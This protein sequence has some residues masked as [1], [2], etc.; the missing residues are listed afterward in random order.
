MALRDA[1]EMH[2]RLFDPAIAAGVLMA[3]YRWMDF[4]GDG[5]TLYQVAGGA[6]AA[7]VAFVVTPIATIVTL[8]S[9]RRA[10]DF[11]RK[12]RG[13]LLSA[14]AWAFFTSV[15]LLGVAIALGAVDGGSAG[16]TSPLARPALLGV[17]AAAVSATCR[18]F[19]M[20]IANLRVRQADSERPLRAVVGE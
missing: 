1:W 19:V 4:P 5:G 8:T 3:S 18:L 16:G 11:D 15:A 12:Y 6:G 13:V 9:G 2:Q 7:L 10:A 17:T 20:F 14:M